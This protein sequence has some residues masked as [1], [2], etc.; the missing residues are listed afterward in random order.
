LGTP[1]FFFAFFPHDLLILLII[2]IILMI[3]V[4]APDF[5]ASVPVPGQLPLARP[6]LKKTRELFFS[7][8]MFLEIFLELFSPMLPKTR[9]K[10]LE[11]IS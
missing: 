9:E 3:I 7:K 11:F 1:V 6:M 5:L 10:N 4:A 2:L 8:F